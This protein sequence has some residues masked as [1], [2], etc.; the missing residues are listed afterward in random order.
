MIRESVRIIEGV[1]AMV[2][3]S[4]ACAG[5]E[6]DWFG[7]QG[8]SS[9]YELPITAVTIGGALLMFNNIDNL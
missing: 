6:K 1:S 8:I 3:G 7:M 9:L 4:V 2:I 5:I